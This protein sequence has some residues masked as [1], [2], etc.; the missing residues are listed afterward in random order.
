MTDT[1]LRPAR[2]APAGTEPATSKPAGTMPVA[3]DHPPAGAGPGGRRRWPWL[4]GAAVAVIALGTAA[5]AATRD[6]PAPAPEPPRAFEGHFQLTVTGSR[7]GVPSVGPQELPQRAA[8]QFCLVD[9][10][11]HN[12]GAEAELLDPGAQRA[13]DS[14]GAEHPVADQALVFL[15]EPQPTL[16]EEIAPGATVKGVLPFDVPAG[17]Q[18]SELVLHTAMDSTGARVPVS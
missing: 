16:L 1:P 12:S 2:L 9:V 18:L 7:C 6:E 14:Q 3:A 8:G 17:V 10:A 15:N 4:V 13:I 11:V 5:F